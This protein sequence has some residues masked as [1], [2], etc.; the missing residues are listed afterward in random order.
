MGRCCSGRLGESAPGVGPDLTVDVDPAASMRLW[1]IELELGGR[2]FD[3]PPLPAA[4]WFPVLTSGDP[5]LILDLLTSGSDDLDE[6]LLAGEITRAE[7]NQALTDAIEQ[8]TGRSFHASFVLA[9]VAAS[10]WP[11]VNGYLAQ[12]GFRWDV[13]PIG[14]ALDAIYALVV[15]NMEKDPREK[16]LRL[17][18]NDALTGGKPARG[19][20]REEVVT[21]FET[22]AGPKPTGGLTATGEQS[23]SARPRTRQRR[24]PPRQDDL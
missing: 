3:V 5:S 6:M 4:D 8:V 14:A 10:Q 19:R 7:L 11:I 20:N 23:G 24:Q 15:G 13:M 21:E 9:T 16:F 12:R 18:D 17:L 1:A 22:L 2:S